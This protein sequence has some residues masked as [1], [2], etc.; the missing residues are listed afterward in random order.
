ILISWVLAKRL[1][2]D[3]A[4]KWLRLYFSKVARVILTTATPSLVKS[5]PFSN[6]KA[7][8]CK[9]RGLVLLYKNL[10][11]SVIIPSKKKLAVLVDTLKGEF[12]THSPNISQVAAL[13]ASTQA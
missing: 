6:K 12:I 3:L 13:S 7:A 4:S 8:V 5:A 2:T 10:P 11:E 9:V 1:T